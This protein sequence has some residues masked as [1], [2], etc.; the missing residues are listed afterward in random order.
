MFFGQRH[1]CIRHN[2]T[3]E[4][5]HLTECDTLNLDPNLLHDVQRLRTR[6]IRDWTVEE[7]NAYAIRIVILRAHLHE[8]ESQGA[9]SR[10]TEDT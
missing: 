7:R 1:R 2:K 6:N 9:I 8:L 3:L 4:D 10:E 5:T